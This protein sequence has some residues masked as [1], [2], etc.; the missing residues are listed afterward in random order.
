MEPDFTRLRQEF[1]ATFP[2]D[3]ITE[4][5]ALSGQASNRRSYRIYAKSGRQY[6]L[7][8]IPVGDAGKRSEEANASSEQQ[9][10]PPFLSVGRY[11]HKV[12]VPVP[13]VHFYL[14]TEGQMLI[15]DLGDR[16]LEQVVT[17]AP[18]E[19]TVFYYKK[20]I[21]TLLDW[22]K[23][24]AAKAAP[25]HMAFKRSFTFELLYWECEHF[26]EYGVEDFYKTRISAEIRKDV[27]EA[28]KRLCQELVALPYC[29]VHR[30]FQSRNLHLY[31]YQMVCIDFQDA[32]MGPFVYDLVALLRDSYV[33]LAPSELSL[34]RDFY[35]EGIR[36]SG[37]VAR[38]GVD[39]GR[40]ERAFHLQTVQRKLKD[41]GR[42][43]YIHTVKKNSQFLP[44]RKPS[45]AY[46][47][48]ALAFLPD[49]ALLAE[50]LHPW[51]G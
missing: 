15:E 48:E 18:S 2:S 43:Q 20:A 26:L 22:Q 44:C 7:M 9:E 3:E 6:I 29:L 5:D 49:Y 32:L 50:R 25:D 10:E 46:V 31:D 37:H 8:Q 19:F 47:R 36:K 4:I 12:G 27:E 14:E 35:W 24:T 39:K 34:L 16:N 38:W 30:D 33:V 1:V 21:E 17:G 42:F 45:L 13:A 51:F 11:L 23:K 28:F 41:A 40:F